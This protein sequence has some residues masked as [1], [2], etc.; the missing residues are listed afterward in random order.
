MNERSFIYLG[1]REGGIFGL[2][3]DGLCQLRAK[4]LDFSEAS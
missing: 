1:G 4:R 2:I 3:V